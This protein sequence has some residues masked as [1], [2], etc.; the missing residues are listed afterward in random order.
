MSN[1]VE[2]PIEEKDPKKGFFG[3]PLHPS[4]H[5][6]EIEGRRIPLLHVREWEGKVEVMLDDR[7]VHIFPDHGTAW[8]AC[9]M[10]ANALAVA[11][12]YS[13]LG[14]KDKNHPFAPEVIEI[15][16]EQWGGK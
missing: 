16:Q 14:A 4:W 8:L 2:F 13:Y 9:S 10:A 6:V 12:G 11:S 3:V 1:I 5:K 7:W 15:S